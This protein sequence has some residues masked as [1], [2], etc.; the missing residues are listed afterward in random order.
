MIINQ[1]LNIKSHFV[2]FSLISD[3]H[4]IILHHFLGI[5]GKFLYY[6]ISLTLTYFSGT[7]GTTLFPCRSPIEKART[8]SIVRAVNFFHYNHIIFFCYK[9]TSLIFF[10]E[11][12]K[13]RSY[14]RRT[15][16]SAHIYSY[17]LPCHPINKPE[18]NNTPHSAVV[19]AIHL[20]HCKC[21]K[22]KR[23][24]GNK[25]HSSFILHYITGHI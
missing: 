25:F 19:Y 15:V 20:F 5:L 13:R 1:K 2:S 11:P 8:F 16:A 17:L 12:I 4:N 23:N 21:I 22:S 24:I 10:H 18:R 9:K 14:S 6:I 7:Y 3:L